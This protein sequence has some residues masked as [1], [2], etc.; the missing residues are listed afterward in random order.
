S[1]VRSGLVRSGGLTPPP[2]PPAMP[3][4]PVLFSRLLKTKKKEQHPHPEHQTRHPQQIQYFIKKNHPTT[5][6]KKYFNP[7]YS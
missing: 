2:Y 4:T 6:N 7:F 1:V 5:R 3:K